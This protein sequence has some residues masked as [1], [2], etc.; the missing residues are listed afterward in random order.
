MKQPTTSTRLGLALAICFSVL[1]AAA[2]AWGAP[3]APG[4]V[5][6]YSFDEGL[7]ST[8]VDASGNGHPGAIVGAAW[9]TGGRYGGALSFD[10]T[11]DYVGLGS[12][13]TFYQ[14]GF[15]LQAW[16]QKATGKSDVAVVG[17]WA[18]SGPMLWVDHLASRYHLTLNGGLSSYLDSG[19]N[20]VLGIWQHVAATYDGSTARYYIDGVQVASRAVGS[21]AGASDVWRIGAY[22]SSPG[23]FF[24]GLIDDVRIYDRALSAAEVQSDMNTP[25]TI[26]N[27][28]I[29]TDP[30][31]FV[32]TARTKT[33]ISVQWS[34][35]TDDIGVTGYRLFLNGAVA[36]TTTGTTH[37]FPSLSCSTS[38]QLGVEA[39]D[40]DDNV[41]TRVVSGESTS[42]CDGPLGLVAAYSFDQGSGATAQDE[43]GNN[44]NG[45]IVGAGWTS[46][47]HGSALSFDG[48]NDHVGLGSLG[49][50][51]Q[52]AFTLQAW[53]QKD[54]TKND[55]AVIGTWTGTGPMLWVDHLAS[56]HRLTLAGGISDYLDSG[57]GPTIGEWQH[58]AATFSGSTARYYVNGVEVA[59]RTV[60]NGAGASDTWRIGAY[61]GSP[62]GFFDG[63]IDDVRIYNRALTATEIQVDMNQPVP[64]KDT[65]PPTPPGTLTATGAVQQVSL[66]WGAATDDVR[67]TRYNVHRSTIAGF[68]P[69]AANRIAQPTGTTH[70]DS[71]LAAGTY[72]YV[73]KAEDWAGNIGPGSNQ[74]TATVAPDTAGPTV[75]VTSPAGG[76]TLSGSVTVTA[77]ATDNQSVAGVQFKLD[78]QSLGAEDTAAPYSLAWDTRG[79][80]NGTHSITAVARDGAGN[81]TTSAPAA[82]TISNAPVSSTGLRAA[83]GL[84]DGSGTIVRDSSEGHQTGT[85]NG[86]WATGGKF[87]GA[88]SL[89]GTANKID[90]PALGTFY[91]TGFTYEAWVFKQSAK[92]DVAIVG[93]WVG[94]EL[95]G[96]MIWIDHAHGRYFLT[97]GE[98]PATYLD[99]GQPAAVGQW[100]HVAAT[101]DGTTARFYVNGVQ[102]ASMLF[103]GNAGN[104]NTWRI[105][106]Y[107]NTPAGFFDGRI[108]NVRIYQ[109]ALSAAEIQTDLASRIQRDVT[110]PTVT[111]FVPANGATSV[112]V[113]D[114]VTVQFNEPMDAATLTANAFEL[115]S[116]SGTPVPVA[117]SYNQSTNVATLALQGALAF[118]TT[119]TATVKP[120]SRRISSAIRSRPRSARRSRR[121][122]RRRRCCWPCRPPIPSAPTWARSSAT[123]A[124]P[125]SRS[126]TPL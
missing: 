58:I 55:V 48:S 26:A 98:S 107:G 36:T 94:T 110:A 121:K 77:T 125:T 69:S 4:I 112:G 126:S 104:S 21:G 92:K 14:G 80:F 20:P 7:G 42:L 123:K 35:S 93:S 116:Q 2:P 40:G 17:T 22:G 51:S 118:G 31:N 61:G 75:A 101:Y 74:A 9:T 59:S 66:A 27:S 24:D 97:L 33:S 34:P 5:A 57:Q 115:K 62:S 96:A 90:L 37:T 29:P 72:Y 105:G 73:V 18:G 30:G 64:P 63:V 53:I 56:R 85:L 46:G 83:Y 113:G 16:V 117:V 79:E 106:A 23:G 28:D 88:A 32:V 122:P 89:D 70:L 95:G 82:V 41:S 6:A 100:Q 99:S 103:S 86:G 43:S 12:L 60:N 19:Q 71:G 45:S 114:S 1:A 65:T 50:F 78:G 39:L 38:Y 68:T 67:L 108:D 44:H 81:T 10:G 111:S 49:T 124:S 11:D 102:T 54:T 15:T 13:G 3:P 47:R 87:G 119:Y 52:T 91:K 8:A 84:D 76:S 109:R 25:V 120:A